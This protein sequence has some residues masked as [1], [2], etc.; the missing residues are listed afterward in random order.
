M[1]KFVIDIPKEI[2]ARIGE[3]ASR[4]QI[5]SDQAIINALGLLL[6]TD[7]KAREGLQLGFVRRNNE[8]KAEVVQIVTDI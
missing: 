7:R 8:G 3:V 1:S 4:L 2:E 5:S 6:V